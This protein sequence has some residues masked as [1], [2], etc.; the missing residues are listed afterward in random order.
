M[1]QL[2]R[3]GAPVR[4]S[5]GTTSTRVLQVN[6]RRASFT[7]LA[8]AANAATIFAAY[9]MP[10]VTA[11]GDRAGIPM[12]PGAQLSEEPPNVFNGEVWAIS[13]VAAQVLIVIEAYYAE[14][15]AP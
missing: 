11:T 13:T 10:T 8:D 7:L 1:A 15:E 14:Q 12:A 6:P 2:V 9:D 3:G 4:V 5:I